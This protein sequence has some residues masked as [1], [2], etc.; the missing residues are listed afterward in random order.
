MTKYYMKPIIIIILCFNHLF[1]THQRVHIIGIEKH[2]D[3]DFTC[4]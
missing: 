3:Y 4:S 2:S 1:R